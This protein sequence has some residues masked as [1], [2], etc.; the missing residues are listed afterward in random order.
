LS[1]SFWSYEAQEFVGGGKSSAT[2]GAQ[3]AGLF[4]RGYPLVMTDRVRKVLAEA[5]ELSAEERAEL[6][7]E[8]LAKLPANEAEHL[9][10]EWLVEI[11]RRARRAHE[12]PDG[13][14]PW[15]EVEMRLLARAS[16]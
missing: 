10:P 3:I 9:H 12:N 11:E 16:R 4:R 8:L 14:E 15:E 7:A 2:R 5:M 1:P 13:G 6:A